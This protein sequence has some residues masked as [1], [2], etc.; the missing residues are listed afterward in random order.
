MARFTYF[1]DLSD[2]AQSVILDF[3]RE[4]RRRKPRAVEGNQV[5]KLLEQA[6]RKEAR[7]G[8]TPEVFGD[9]G[10]TLANAIAQP[11]TYGMQARQECEELVATVAKLLAP[12]AA[13]EEMPDIDL[14]AAS[15]EDWAKMEAWEA[16]LEGSVV[17][18]QYTDQARDMVERFAAA[19]ADKVNLGA[20]R[21]DGHAHRAK[22]G[23]RRGRRSH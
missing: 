14:E 1:Q 4:L 13:E 7:I 17:D 2:D 8:T 11:K 21:S 20:G 18:Q 15:P 5:A 9:V 16:R 6:D 10:V 19:M 3:E 22:K 12:A 23:T